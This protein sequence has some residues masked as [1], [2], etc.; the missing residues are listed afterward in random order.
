MVIFSNQIQKLKLFFVLDKSILPYDQFPEAT[1]GAPGRT[2]KV[3]CRQQ[4]QDHG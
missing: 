4:V 1:V 2:D 3:P